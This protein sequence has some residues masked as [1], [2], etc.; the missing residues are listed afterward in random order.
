MLIGILTD[1]QVEV[2]GIA[3]GKRW[4]PFAPQGPCT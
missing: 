4:M 3:S 1:R 2:I